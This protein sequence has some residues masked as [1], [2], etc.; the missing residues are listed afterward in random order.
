[1]SVST[2]LDS[3][4]FRTEIVSS[5]CLHLTL[6]YCC[7]ELPIRGALLISNHYPDKV[8]SIADGARSV[9]VEDS[10]GES[11]LVPEGIYVGWMLR[12]P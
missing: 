8:L 7:D 1:M 5:L 12:R 3:L 11:H 10:V 9:R 4:E 6:A 2:F